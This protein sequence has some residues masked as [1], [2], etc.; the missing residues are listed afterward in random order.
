MQSRLARRRKKAVSRPCGK[1]IKAPACLRSDQPIRGGV[2]APVTDPRGRHGGE[3]AGRQ[4]KRG[5]GRARTCCG[6]GRAEV[7][8]RMTTPSADQHQVIH[9]GRGLEH[10]R[11]IRCRAAAIDTYSSSTLDPLHRPA[12]RGS[13]R[14]RIRESSKAV[15]GLRCS[16]PSAYGCDGPEA[17]G[18]VYG[19]KSGIPDVPAHHLLRT[20]F[21]S[22]V[23]AS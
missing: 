2:A 4:G 23:S 8:G 6:E 3:R 20:R 21:I 11:S 14:Q 15:V 17:D 16:V 22:V 10:G 5:G 18:R 13:G 19:D 9:A 7:A 1:A 12:G